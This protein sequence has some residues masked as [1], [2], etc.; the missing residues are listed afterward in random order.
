MPHAVTSDY[1]KLYYEDVG[2]GTPILLVLIS[3]ICRWFCKIRRNLTA[4]VNNAGPEKSPLVLA[5]MVPG[6]PMEWDSCERFSYFW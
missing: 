6:N 3:P 4:F 5:A 1:V 2:Q